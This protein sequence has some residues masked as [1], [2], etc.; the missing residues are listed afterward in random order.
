MLAFMC[1]SLT[2]YDFAVGETLSFAVYFWDKGK[3][4]NRQK[5]LVAGQKKTPQ[6]SVISKVS[7]AVG[8]ARP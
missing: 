2:P 8:V 1:V 4:G 3:E 7:V 6:R 5:P